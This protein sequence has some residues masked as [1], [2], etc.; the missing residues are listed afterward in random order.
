MH[1]RPYQTY[2]YDV[3]STQLQ[4][5]IKKNCNITITVQKEQT[6]RQTILRL[7]RK[8]LCLISNL[9]LNFKNNRLINDKNPIKVLHSAYISV[10]EGPCV[11]YRTSI[12][13][14]ISRSSFSIWKLLEKSKNGTLTIMTNTT[15][16]KAKSF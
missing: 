8:C 12:Y 9:W 4:E 11:H 15:L 13:V 6:D 5:P 3:E 16:L 10:W 7:W 1:W 2:K 14:W